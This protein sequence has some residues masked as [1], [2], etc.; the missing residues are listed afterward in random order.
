MTA[1]AHRRDARAGLSL[2]EVLVVLAII[3]TAAGASLLG[4]GLLDRGGAETEARRLADR[5]QL[6]ADEAI[7]TSRPMAL[8][9]D[10]RGYRFVE[11]DAAAGRWQESVR[12]A[13]GPRHALPPALRLEPSDTAE[14]APV[15][16]APD[17]PEPA[18]A[19]RLVGEAQS[20]AVTFD[21]FAA[22]AG[23]VGP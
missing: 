18:A 9:W 8:V 6:A 19:L 23:P 15:L 1:A 7:V 4:A 20:W 13:L 16:I 5:L 3:G 11:W 12:F 22:V 10:A 14:I 2:I 17:L 21:G